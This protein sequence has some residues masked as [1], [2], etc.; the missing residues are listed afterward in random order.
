MPT[1]RVPGRIVS[2]GEVTLAAA[3]E[4]EGDS[5]LRKF[6]MVAYTGGKMTLDGWPAPVV[7][8]LSGM[9]VTQKARPILRDHDP[10]KIVGH[11][12]DVRIEPQRVHVE[13][14][15]SSGNGHARDVETAADNGFPWQASIGASVTKAVYV[16]EGE[17]VTVNGR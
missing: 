10:A 3:A 15:L 14:V 8:D 1:D 11:T 17:T 12:T 9:S 6:S 16:E 4:G 2:S 7:V 13:G 5:R